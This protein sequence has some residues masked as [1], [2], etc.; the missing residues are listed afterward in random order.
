MGVVQHSFRS[1]VPEEDSIRDADMPARGRRQHTRLPCVQL[2]ASEERVSTRRRPSRDSYSWG[3]AAA[4]RVPK[5]RPSILSRRFARRDPIGRGARPSAPSVLEPG[6]WLL[7][8]SPL[9]AR[10][11]SI[12]EPALQTL[13][14]AIRHAHERQDCSRRS[15]SSGEPS[16]CTCGSGKAAGQGPRTGFRHPQVANAY[17]ERWVGTARRELCD[18][19]LIWNH[20][21]LEQ[22]LHEY[23]EHYNTHRPNRALR[24]RAPDD[25]DVVAYRPG[26]Q[27]R[28]HPTCSGLIN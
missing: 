8:A 6:D 15:R 18:R 27:I 10:N 3:G 26:Q 13:E 11:A 2:N 14:R 16:H 19:T 23:V 5:T 21:Q 20:R 22:L 17:A 12:A 1:H 25:R 7:T 24:Q 4:L 28:R 9:S